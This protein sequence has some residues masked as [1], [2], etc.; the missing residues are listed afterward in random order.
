MADNQ[1]HY[2]K[3]TREELRNAEVTASRFLEDNSAQIADTLRA[4][5]RFLETLVQR[6][7]MK[8][9]TFDDR[10]EYLARV[11]EIA[12]LI[13]ADADGFFEL[14]SNPVVARILTTVSRKK[15]GR[16]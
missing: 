12:Q 10:L 7:S 13:Q 5:T 14:A 11:S 1:R 9:T 4:K 3:W 8:Q 6:L 2:G 16:P 15:P